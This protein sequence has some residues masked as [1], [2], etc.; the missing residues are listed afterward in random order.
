MTP[1]WRSCRKCGVRYE[2]IKKKCP[3]CATKAPPPR[4]PKHARTLQRDSYEVFERF[5][6]EVH[7]PAFGG[8]WSADCCGVCGKPPSQDRHNDR[9]H[10]H[11]RVSFTFGKPRGLACGGNQGCN[12]LMVPWVTAAAAEGIAEAKLVAGEPDAQ[13]WVLVAA[14]LERV[15]AHYR[16]ENG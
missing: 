15:D 10:G 6:G 13:R 11:L 8:D 16:K 3:G 14:Y 5:N 12:I 2:R 7:G 4:V 1:R 9:D